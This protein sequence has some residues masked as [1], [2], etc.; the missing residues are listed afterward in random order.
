MLCPVHV[1]GWEEAKQLAHG[2]GQADQ[3]PLLFGGTFPRTARL[4]PVNVQ[5]CGQLVASILGH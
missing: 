1:C 5:L 4:D 2:H 3:C